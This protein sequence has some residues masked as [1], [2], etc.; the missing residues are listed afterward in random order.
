[1]LGAPGIAVLMLTSSGGEDEHPQIPALTP[2]QAVL[3][4]KA[5]PS[6]QGWPLC[7]CPCLT[8]Q[9][10]FSGGEALECVLA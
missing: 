4:E 3:E 6:R 9:G 8:T 10:G 2:V 5:V 7:L 1:M